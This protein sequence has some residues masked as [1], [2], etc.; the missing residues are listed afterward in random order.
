MRELMQVDQHTTPHRS[1]L[2]FLFFRLVVPRRVLGWASVDSRLVSRQAH[3]TVP[4]LIFALK[5]F[6]LK[7]LCIF[8]KVL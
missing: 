2:N 8:P 5:D 4:K 7:A 6:L 1:A 3:A